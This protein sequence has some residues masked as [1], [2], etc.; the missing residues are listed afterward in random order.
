MYQRF[1]AEVEIEEGKDKGLG[2]DDPMKLQN[3][4]PNDKE[5]NNIDDDADEKEE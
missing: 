5:Y 3:E 2:D 1:R 4:V